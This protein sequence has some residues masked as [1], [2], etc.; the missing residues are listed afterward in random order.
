MKRYEIKVLKLRSYDDE[1][2]YILPQGQSLQKDSQFNRQ[3]MGVFHTGW[4]PVI[5]TNSFNY[6]RTDIDHLE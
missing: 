3:I 1:K 4:L 5:R 2:P 6:F